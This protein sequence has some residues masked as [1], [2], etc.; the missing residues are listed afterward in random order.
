[1]VSPQETITATNTPTPRLDR[2][3]IAETTEVFTEYPSNGLLPGRMPRFWTGVIA[4][5]LFAMSLFVL[6]YFLMLGCGVGHHQGAFVMTWGVAWWYIVTACIA[7]FAGGFISP[8]V[9]SIP[10]AGW[11]RGAALWGL[12]IPLA[13][14]LG[15]FS[16]GS[17]AIAVTNGNLTVSSAF[18]AY[19]AN[20]S[21]GWMMFCILLAGLAFAVFGASSGVN[22]MENL[23]S[24]MSS[25]IRR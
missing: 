12:S 5:T 21:Y 3:F 2:G 24:P 6:S 9:G 11:L 19:P 8:S 18:Y 1:M 16:A 7:Y 13:C 22:A 14:L 15:A 4:G 17:G 23:Q 20:A 25:Q 10:V